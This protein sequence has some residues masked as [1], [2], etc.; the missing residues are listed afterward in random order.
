L[1]EVE[2]VSLLEQAMA[3]PANKVKVATVRVF[4]PH[5]VGH[6]HFA[7]YERTR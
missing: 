5:M 4:I 6:K 1:D 3:R 2:V 7:D